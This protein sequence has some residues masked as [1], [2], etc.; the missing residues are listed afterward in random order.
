MAK[1]VISSRSNK[2][3]VGKLVEAM[4]SGNSAEFASLFSHHD[5]PEVY[6]LNKSHQ[7]SRALRL[8]NEVILNI[9]RQVLTQE[10]ADCLLESMSQQEQLTDLTKICLY[11]ITFPFTTEEEREALFKGDG[12]LAFPQ[13]NDEIRNEWATAKK[14]K[15]PELEQ[16]NLRRYYWKSIVKGQSPKDFLE[17]YSLARQ[18]DVYW[19]EEM[20]N[21]EYYRCE[22]IDA[23]ANYRKILDSVD[24]DSQVGFYNH[25]GYT[26]STYKILQD[27]QLFDLNLSTH[28][29]KN[30]PGLFFIEEA[31]NN[32]KTSLVEKFVRGARLFDKNHV[33]VCIDMLAHIDKSNL[34]D[35]C[36]ATK[37]K[38]I[39][40]KEEF[41]DHWFE[42]RF[43][44]GGPECARYIVEMIKDDNKK[45]N[46]RID[47]R[48]D[49]FRSFN[50][51]VVAEN[52][53]YGHHNHFARKNHFE[54][55]CQE[56]IEFFQ[57]YADDIEEECEKHQLTE[58]QLKLAY[59]IKGKFEGVVSLVKEALAASKEEF[60][61]RKPQA[62]AI[63]PTEILTEEQMKSVKG[64]MSEDEVEYGVHPMSRHPHRMG[65]PG[66]MRRGPRITGEDREP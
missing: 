63:V 12:L 26:F 5:N 61:T 53:M 33:D 46:I 52:M 41:I 1:E 36:L 59:E 60:D 43:A 11:L 57:R 8:L 65:M 13:I 14:W 6:R 66:L 16:F 38:I 39:Q 44:A 30:H 62:Y 32:N 7:G 27:Y 24:R 49:S 25:A 47:R 34:Q 15:D 3:F 42:L 45:L 64:F 23:D 31:V 56:H 54:D 48:L 2:K 58:H 50:R 21:L 9:P 35:K 22:G 51:N 19:L 40:L 17:I 29:S 55:Y 10:M 18:L 28:D 37:E 4:N 20:S